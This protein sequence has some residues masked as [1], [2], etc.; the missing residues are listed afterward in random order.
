MSSPL[1]NNRGGDSTDAPDFNALVT[2]YVHALQRACAEGNAEG[3]KPGTAATANAFP[4]ASPFQLLGMGSAAPN[5]RSFE[6][7]PGRVAAGEKKAKAAKAKP[8][9]K[10]AA[11]RAP[12]LLP[13]A[14]STGEELLRAEFRAKQRATAAITSDLVE[15]PELPEELAYLG[16]S[17]SIC[18]NPEVLAGAS[19]KGGGKG[20]KEKDAGGKKAAK[21][22]AAPAAKSKKAADA[23]DQ[24][25]PWDPL[26]VLKAAEPGM[27]HRAS[28]MLVHASTIGVPILPAADMNDR[29]SQFMLAS[30][31]ATKLEKQTEWVIK[32]KAKK[33]KGKN[34]AAAKKSGG[35]GGAVFVDVSAMEAK[36]LA[37]ELDQLTAVPAEIASAAS[38]AQS[39]YGAP[40]I[41]A[42]ASG[43][44]AAEGAGD[45]TGDGGAAGSHS[46]VSGPL[47]FTEED[48]NACSA[49][50][51]QTLMH[52]AERISS[53]SEASIAAHGEPGADPWLHIGGATDLS[54][55][56]PLAASLRSSLAS[57][58]TTSVAGGSQGKTQYLSRP[59]SA[60]LPPSRQLL[61][62]AAS[63]Q[64]YTGQLNVLP[65]ATR[66]VRPASAAGSLRAATFVPAPTLNPRNAFMQLVTSPTGKTAAASDKT[67]SLPLPSRPA[68]SPLQS[69]QRRLPMGSPKALE[70]SAVKELLSPS[71]TRLAQEPGSSI[72]RTT[73]TSA[74]SGVAYFRN[75]STLR[76]SS[77]MNAVPGSDAASKPANMGA[78][79]AAMALQ[80][81]RSSLSRHG[82]ATAP[83]GHIPVIALPPPMPLVLGFAPMTTAARHVVRAM[84]MCESALDAAFRG[85][86]V[87]AFATI[88]E[89]EDIWTQ[90]GYVH[91]GCRGRTLL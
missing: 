91:H 59:P 50:L 19:G 1:L 62:H 53:T 12:I 61:A 32:E 22:A 17:L 74:A 38:K 63:R 29:V 26:G 10:V 60:L 82:R 33:A 57:T 46:A 90:H 65:S 69:P 8:A 42:N 84:E 35:K 27:L 39:L 73:A 3:G 75:T 44:L 47:H 34:K 15:V 58:T 88:R 20:G 78:S 41:A 21:G 81:I 5:M 89:A 52:N 77:M 66:S 48:F 49:S 56:G 71:F 18:A 28:A 11:D 72:R 55:T 86:P 16:T 13:L 51:L 83:I 36:A 37:A 70:E 14:F 64:Q 40:S 54:S 80:S 76:Y 9:G 67:E 6:T 7:A 79:F 45:G 23:T 31:A 24:R 68:S 43:P 87:K 25:P 85:M 2:A 30:A 4:E